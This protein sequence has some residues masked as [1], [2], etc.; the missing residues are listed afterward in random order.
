M[1][2]LLASGR[3]LSRASGAIVGNPTIVMFTV[4]GGD[5]MIKKLWLKV[6][7][8]VAVDGGTLAVQINPT[9]GDT[10]TLVTATNLGTTDTVAGSV[11]GLDAAATAAPSFLRG[12]RVDIN[13]VATT[14]DIELV[15]A[16][17]VDGNV[18]MYVEWEPITAGATVVAA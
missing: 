9:A 7:T 14:G 12:G 18:T 16:A 17:G 10:M 8:A 2:P 11:V 13:A 5:V 4:A 6:T 1:E 15:G 3:I